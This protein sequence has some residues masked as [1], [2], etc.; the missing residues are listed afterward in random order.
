MWRQCSECHIL[1]DGKLLL[2]F[3]PLHLTHQ[4]L[5]QQWAAAAPHSGTIGFHSNLEYWWPNRRQRLW[6]E[7]VGNRTCTLPLNHRAGL[8]FW[9]DIVIM[10]KCQYVEWVTTRWYCCNRKTE[11]CHRTEVNKASASQETSTQGWWSVNIHTSTNTMWWCFFQIDV[12]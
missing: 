5:R 2:Y 6:S 1:K 3:H 7:P 11:V 9:R 10:W 12:S 4:P 8:W